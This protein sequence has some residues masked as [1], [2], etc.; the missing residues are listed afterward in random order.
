MKR[1][2]P[3]LQRLCAACTVALALVAGAQP[4]WAQVSRD[5]AAAAAAQQTGGRVL[6]V[7]RA[8]SGQ[9]A[10]WRVK[11][12]TPRG[13]VRVVHIDAGAGGGGNGGPGRGARGRGG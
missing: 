4:A 3:L 1:P 9:G 10:V 8:E 5:Q 6:S 11:V 2:I 12:V 13:E 7:E